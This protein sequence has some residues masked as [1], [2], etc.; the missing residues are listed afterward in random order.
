LKLSIAHLE[1][2]SYILHSDTHQFT[3][4]FIKD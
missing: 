1:S 2:G 3:L 4:K